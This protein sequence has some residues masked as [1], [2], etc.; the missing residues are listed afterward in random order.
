MHSTPAAAHTFIAAMSL[1]M[2][3]EML[4]RRHRRRYMVMA[5]GD[6][7]IIDNSIDRQ[8]RLHI[9]FATDA[10]NL[11]KIIKSEIQTLD[12]GPHVQA[13]QPKYIASARIDCRPKAFI[14]STGAID[15]K[16]LSRFITANLRKIH[17]FVC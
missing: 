12:R 13:P 2:M 5:F 3:A 7:L 14:H 10:G 9:V 11:L 8:I 4:A 6:I 15:L 16:N 17:I 1:A